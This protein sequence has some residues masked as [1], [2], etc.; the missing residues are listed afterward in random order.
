MTGARRSLWIAGAPVRVL[1][2]ALIRLYRVT[3]G[4][5]IGGGCRFYPSCSAYAEDAIRNTGALRGFPLAVWRVLRCS[6][7]SG[8]GVDHAPQAR[9]PQ[10]Y[11]PDTQ[12]KPQHPE[13][14][15][16]SIQSEADR[17][18]GSAA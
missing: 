10:Q 13:E 5:M 8:G 3:L 7:L 2:I 11:V 18:V 4:Q 6:P 1:L 17:P 12:R 9:F 16:D 14:Y 15:E